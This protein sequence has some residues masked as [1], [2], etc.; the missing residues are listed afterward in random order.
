MK[1]QIYPLKH[2]ELTLDRD[3]IV[4]F[5][6]SGY[7]QYI[8]EDTDHNNL[9]GSYRLEKGTKITCLNASIKQMTVSIET[10]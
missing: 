7:G 8:V 3:S 6:P 4:F 2:V 9:V 10:L 1:I 5:E